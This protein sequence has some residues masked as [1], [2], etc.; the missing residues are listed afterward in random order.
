MCTNKFS[1]GGLRGVHVSSIGNWGYGENFKPDY[2][3]FF[4]LRKNF[5][6]TK[7]LTNAKQATFT[8]LE[9]CA[10]KKPLPLLFFSSLIF[11]LLVNVCLWVFLCARNLFIKTKINKQVWNFLRNLNYLYY[12]LDKFSLKIQN[13]WFQL[14]IWSK[15]NSNMQNFIGV[16]TFFF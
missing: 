5:T 13:L 6:S 4:F 8:P 9:V 11:V 2:F 1:I 15:N 14:K 16:F 3:F 10:H 7:T 12:F